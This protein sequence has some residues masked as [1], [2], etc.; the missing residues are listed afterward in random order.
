MKKFYMAILIATLIVAGTALTGEIKPV[1]KKT[2]CIAGV[3]EG[4]NKLTVSKTCPEPR[5]GKF[6]MYLYQEEG[7]GSK[8]WGK[9]VDPANPAEPLTM[10]GTVTP[11]KDGCCVIEGKASK[12]GEWTEF[13][14]I[15]CMVLGKWTIRKGTYT[16]SD[17]CSGTFGMTWVRALPVLR[18]VS[19]K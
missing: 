5:S 19:V 9:I 2:C 4:W 6:T 14:G 15:I 13:K 10:K 18:P 8:I 3:Y 1:L 7:C 17:G 12:P 16:D 11:G